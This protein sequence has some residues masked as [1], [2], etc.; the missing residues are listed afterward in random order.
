MDAPEIRR[1]E[2][3][4]NVDDRMPFALVDRVRG[5][6]TEDQIIRIGPLPAWLRDYAF[7]CELADEVTYQ[8]EFLLRVEDTIDRWRPRLHSVPKTE[9][10]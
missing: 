7:E 5:S 10:P 8:G 2:V 3:V 1:F 4:D 6:K 9:E